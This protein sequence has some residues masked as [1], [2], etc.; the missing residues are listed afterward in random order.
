MFKRIALTSVLCAL[1]AVPSAF[2]AGADQPVHVTGTIMDA[3]CGAGVTSQADAEKHTKECSLM[4]HCAES[5]F[6]IVIDGKFHK[7]DAEGSKKAEALGRASSKK[8][9]IDAAVEGTMHEDGTIAVTSLAE[10]K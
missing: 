7:L 2:A 5:G 1:V 10:T 4:A 3:M 9:H 8:D 6:G